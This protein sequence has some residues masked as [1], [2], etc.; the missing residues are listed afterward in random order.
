[1]RGR[2]PGQI[3]AVVAIAQFQVIVPF[4]IR[5]LHLRAKQNSEEKP[6]HF[7]SQNE[8]QVK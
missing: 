7:L 4:S 8:V 2:S 5:V 6:A 1:M 3:A